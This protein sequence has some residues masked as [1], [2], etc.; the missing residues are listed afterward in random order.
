MQDYQVKLPAQIHS[1]RSP[2]QANGP[3]AS[4]EAPQ[5]LAKSVKTA[6]EQKWCYACY[7]PRVSSLV[8]RESSIQEKR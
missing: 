7:W 1:W 6:A 4:S 8:R 2:G 3:T 5:L